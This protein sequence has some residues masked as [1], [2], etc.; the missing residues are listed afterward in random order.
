MTTEKQTA[1]NQANAQKSTGP[2]SETGKAASSKNHLITG[3]FTRQDYVKPEERDI[4]KIFYDTMF[5]DLGPVTTLEQSYVNEIAG[6]AWRLRRCSAVEGEL[7]DYREQDPLL[8]EKAEKIIRSL[9]RARASAHSLMNRS[10]NQLRKIQ[11]ERINRDEID[12]SKH[13]FPA[14]A[15][16]GKTQQ[17][18]IA[19]YRLD[20]EMRNLQKDAQSLEAAQVDAAM[21]AIMN[22]PAPNWADIDITATSEKMASNCQTPQPQPNASHTSRPG[23]IPT[24][25]PSER[26]ANGRPKVGRN[27]PCPCGS[28][29]KFKQCCLGK[30]A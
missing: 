22:E 23:L 18:L 4:Y 27:T 24:E 15:D 13:T 14:L 30:A 1:A 19:Q 20:K 2:A 3:L 28:G 29:L 17:A 8:D 5:A 25:G 11:T 16:T 6:A 26:I 10:V 9:E 12:W 21:Q 7:S